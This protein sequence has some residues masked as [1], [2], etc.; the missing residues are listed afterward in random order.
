MRKSA[1]TRKFAAGGTL[2]VVA[3]IPILIGLSCEDAR[4]ADGSAPM[5]LAI[6]IVKGAD[7]EIINPVTVKFAD[8]LRRELDPWWQSEG[9]LI[10]TNAWRIG[11]S[12]AYRGGG[13]FA[14][15]LVS[16]CELRRPWK[17]CSLITMD[18]V[19]DP[20]ASARLVAATITGTII[21]QS[22]KELTEK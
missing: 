11:I 5:A 21:R 12:Q 17:V 20:T 9:R 19:S 22:G 14:G 4:A 16:C 7:D 10:A 13:T 18:R 6:E 3:L 8:V 1:H 15:L 2:T